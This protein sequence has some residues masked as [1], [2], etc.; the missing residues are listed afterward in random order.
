MCSLHYIVLQNFLPM[1]SI[2][3]SYKI[4][5]CFFIKCP[6]LFYHWI[7][8]EINTFFEFIVLIFFNSNYFVGIKNTCIISFYNPWGNQIDQ[9]LFYIGQKVF[10]LLM[11]VLFQSIEQI[12]SKVK[13]KCKQDNT[14]HTYP[15]GDCLLNVYFWI[16][17]KYFEQFFFK[18]WKFSSH[19]YDMVCIKYLL[20]SVIFK[21]IHVHLWILFYLKTLV[22]M[23]S[24]C[25]WVFF[26]H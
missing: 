7:I 3:P 10:Y 1:R 8:C 26:I 20:K 25:F 24:K 12:I 6:F 4:I 22:I 14:S 11:F 13:L 16:F 15:L 9:N 21:N 19:Y 23:I 5:I 17:L 2:N 18:S